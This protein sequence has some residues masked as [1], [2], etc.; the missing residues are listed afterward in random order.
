[1]FIISGE[2]IPERIPRV[3]WLA[4]LAQSNES[5]IKEKL[6]LKRQSS[7]WEGTH[8]R[9]SSGLHMHVHK[10]ACI[11]AHPH[12]L[13]IYTAIT[14]QSQ[15]SPFSVKKGCVGMVRVVEWSVYGWYKTKQNA[16]EKEVWPFGV[17]TNLS[18]CIATHRSYALFLQSYLC[19][20][21]S[22][23]FIFY[24]LFLRIYVY[25]YNAHMFC[26]HMYL[27]TM[28]N[29]VPTEEWVRS[30]TWV[31]DG[32]EPPH[33]FWALNSGRAV[34]A[35][36]HWAISPGH[37]CWYTFNTTVFSLVQDKVTCL[38]NHLLRYKKKV[39][40]LYHLPSRE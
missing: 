27:C 2:K 40:F 30:G 6:L 4:K 35:L 29:L 17:E 16:L 12:P 13:G 38:Q 32:C 22:P 33:G 25:F 11:C 24:P 5:W 8:V 23:T 20:D 39:C 3:C 1:M 19:I 15:I 7:P 10:R 34:S 18:D 26:L 36:N 14:K 37:I 21:E 28:G 9:L 31:T